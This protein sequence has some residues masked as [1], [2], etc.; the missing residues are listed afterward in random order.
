MPKGNVGLQIDEHAAWDRADW[1]IQRVGWAVLAVIVALGLL[2]LF[3]NGLLTEATVGSQ[4]E[5]LWM[6]YPRV[7]RLGAPVTIDVHVDGRFVEGGEVTISLSEGYLDS[8]RLEGISPEPDSVTTRQDVIEYM[9]RVEG[10]GGVAV[11]FYVKAQELGSMSGT[12]A[13]AGGGSERF[14]QFVLP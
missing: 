14:R 2:G 7:V 4:S 8:V 13:V 1:L 10:G 5:G 12:V 3:G 11:A 9:F 6:E